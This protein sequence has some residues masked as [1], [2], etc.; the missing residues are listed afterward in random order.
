MGAVESFDLAL[1]YQKISRKRRGYKKGMLP[2]LFMAKRVAIKPDN[3]VFV[4]DSGSKD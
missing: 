1:R 2:L 4:Y 3:H